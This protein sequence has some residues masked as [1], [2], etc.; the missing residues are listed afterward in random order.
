MAVIAGAVTQVLVHRFTAER[1]RKA[2]LREKAE[3]VFVLLEEYRTWV[4]REMESPKSEHETP[5]SP[6]H[7]AQAIIGLYFPTAAPLSE[8]LK[9]QHGLL[10]DVAFKMHGG[11]PKPSDAQ[12]SAALQA[13]TMA[14]SALKRHVI[15]EARAV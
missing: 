10:A 3:K 4:Y 12:V 8:A 14:L 2:L 13:H 15:E 5:T 6:S 9:V 7:E 1:E 11:E